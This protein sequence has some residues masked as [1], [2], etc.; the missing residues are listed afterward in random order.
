MAKN[1]KFINYP[2]RVEKVA[3]HRFPD[4]E[5]RCFAEECLMVSSEHTDTHIIYN[6]DVKSNANLFLKLVK[7]RFSD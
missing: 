5:I 1:N 4:E 6:F 2:V 7:G 3:G